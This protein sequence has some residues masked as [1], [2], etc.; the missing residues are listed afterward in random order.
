MMF[1]QQTSHI[2][3]EFVSVIKLISSVICHVWGVDGVTIINNISTTMTQTNI[4][5]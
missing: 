2:S 4:F 5:D 1:L 3:A